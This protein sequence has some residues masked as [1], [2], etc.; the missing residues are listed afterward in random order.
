MS[1]Y[2]LPRTGDALDTRK[3]PL[4]FGDYII[5][6]QIEESIRSGITRDQLRAKI[7]GGATMFAHKKKSLIPDIGHENTVVARNILRQEK[8]MVTA[9]H[10]AG[11]IGRSI[12]FNPETKVLQVTVFGEEPVLL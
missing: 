12:I 11:T 8:I 9:E 4:R 6:L 7:A 3:Q 2:L 10:T 1:H 5:P